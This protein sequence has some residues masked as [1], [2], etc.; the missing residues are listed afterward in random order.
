MNGTKTQAYESKKMIN[1]IKTSTNG[2]RLGRFNFLLFTSSTVLS[3]NLIN[4][5]L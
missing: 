4:I 1:S 3:I 2:V 5:R